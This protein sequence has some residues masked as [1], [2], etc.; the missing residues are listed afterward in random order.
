MWTLICLSTGFAG[1]AEKQHQVAF[2]H[3]QAECA[4]ERD[5]MFG[6][7]YYICAPAELNKDN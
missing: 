1:F 4:A 5:R 6:K 3:T 7:S 2:F